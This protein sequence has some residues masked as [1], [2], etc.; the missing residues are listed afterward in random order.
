MVK[1]DR[2]DNRSRIHFSRADYACVD[3]GCFVKRKV[4]VM[5]HRDLRVT[6]DKDVGSQ[7]VR[8]K[9]NKQEPKRCRVRWMQ[10]WRL[11]RSNNVLFRSA[12]IAIAQS[13]HIA[14]PIALSTNRAQTERSSNI[15]V[16]R[17]TERQLNHPPVTCE[18]TVDMAQ[19]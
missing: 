18:L 15:L 17:S 2:F 16:N 1:S 7:S 4:S 14:E 13:L 12:I 3:S 5:M 8:W 11:D 10:N 19:W 9:R 6:A